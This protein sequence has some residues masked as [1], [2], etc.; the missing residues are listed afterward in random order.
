MVV[1]TIGALSP[2]FD[3]RSYFA[4]PTGV[5]DSTAA[6][7]NANTAATAAGGL[8]Y[9]VGTFKISGTV[10]ITTYCDFSQATFNV[11]SGAVSPAVYVGY[12]GA[13]LSFVDLRLPDVI[14]TGKGALGSGVWAANTGVE[15]VNANGC[16]VL[17]GHVQGFGT[18]TLLTSFGQGHA[19]NTYFVGT[20]DNNKVGLSLSPGDSGAWVN[21]NAFFGGR[22]THHAGEGSNIS[23]ARCILSNNATSPPNNNTFVHVSVESDGA[24]YHLEDYGSDNIYEACRWEAVA[25]KVHF[26]GTANSNVIL[27]GYDADRIVVTEDSGALYN[28]LFT[29][30]SIRTAG[31]GA[32]GVFVGAARGSD[33]YPVFTVVSGADKLSSDPAARYLWRASGN[34]MQ[35]KQATDAGPRFQI[36]N[37]NGIVSWGFGS[38]AF[39][40]TLT[41]AT[42]V[43]MLLNTKL[44]AT[45]GIGVGN[46]AAATT[47]GSVVKKIEVFDTAGTSLGFIAVYSAIT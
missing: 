12:A 4:D 35:G 11:A 17:L 47:P 26:A 25:P 2:T 18:G 37:D 41:P 15:I 30:N 7:N 45:A 22:I 42:S 32:G 29:R 10:T 13:P 38:G 39:S 46:S 44:L 36:E 34:Y 31:A 5:T 1:V 6:L 21:E 3:V 33:S 9:G 27:Y 8:L 43:G 24:E 40:H 28:H 16:R 14:F 23:G 19:Y 20:Q